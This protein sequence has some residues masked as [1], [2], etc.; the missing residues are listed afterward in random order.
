[1]SFNPSK[2]TEGS[3]KSKPH[4]TLT[5]ASTDEQL[6]ISPLAIKDDPLKSLDTSIQV[7]IEQ[8]LQMSLRN[9]VYVKLCHFSKTISFFYFAELRKL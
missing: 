5:L 1:M 4:L 3:S 7:L 2:T 8:Y 6:P 9:R